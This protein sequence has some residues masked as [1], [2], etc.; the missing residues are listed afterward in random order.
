MKHVEIDTQTGEEVV[1][2][3]PDEIV[4][5]PPQMPTSEERIAAL[6]AALLDQLLGGA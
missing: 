1:T 4:D 6:E 5:M 3:L 2:E